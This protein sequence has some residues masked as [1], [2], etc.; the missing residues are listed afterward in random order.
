[1]EMI[2]QLTTEG[3]IARVGAEYTKNNDKVLEAQMNTVFEEE[4][5]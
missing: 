4:K 2:A 5:V 1:M 3:F